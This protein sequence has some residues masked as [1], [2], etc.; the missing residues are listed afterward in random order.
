MIKAPKYQLHDN[1]FPC[2]IMTLNLYKM[3]T[4]NQ[5]VQYARVKCAGRIKD[6]IHINPE[7]AINVECDILES[8]YLA[9]L[10]KKRVF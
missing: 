2:Q 3:E 4:N 1:I 9:G 7:S 6:G 8:N 10:D 5:S